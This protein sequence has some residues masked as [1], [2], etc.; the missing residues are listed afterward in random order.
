MLNGYRVL[1][2]I[3]SGGFSLI[4]LAEDEESFD[5]VALKEYFPKRF[6]AREGAR[7]IRPAGEEQQMS[8]DRGRRLF[9][10]EVKTLATLRHPSIVAVSHC[11]LANGTAYSVLGYEPGTSLARFIQERGGGLSV[12]FLM[13]VFPPLLDALELIH[14]HRHLHLDIKPSNVRLR[15]GGRPLLLDFGSA[16]TLRHGA[17]G[18]KAKLVTAG[19]SP[20]E[21]YGS[22]EEIGP[23]TD[24]YAVGATM[25]TCL[26]GRAPP[27]A[28]ERLTGP[29]LAPATETHAGRYPSWLLEAIDW[30]MRLRPLDRPSTA[31]ELRDHLLAHAPDE[32][33]DWGA[34]ETRSLAP[35]PER[36]DFINDDQ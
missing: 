13:T 5:Q 9:F 33:P 19:Y 24:V 35:Q 12:R 27:A 18:E 16:Y 8:F 3:G 10:Q 31:S 6:A 32:L 30:A 20:P 29:A 34:D 23:W 36:T 21:Q 11:F 2:Q 7:R 26:D 17:A 28:A 25:R 22:G 15:P 4:Y 1:R 14:R